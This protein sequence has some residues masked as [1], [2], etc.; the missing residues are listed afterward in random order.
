MRAFINYLSDP[1]YS[2][3]QT[4]VLVIG[5]TIGMAVLM[6]FERCGESFS[7]ARIIRLAG[8]MQE[9]MIKK[10]VNMDLMCYDCDAYYEIG[11]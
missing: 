2:F 1:E 10:V 6:A 4:A 9:E 11:I 3:G 7:K 8:M 5:A